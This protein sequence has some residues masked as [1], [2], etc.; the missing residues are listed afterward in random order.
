MHQPRPFGLF[1]VG[2]GSSPYTP[3]DAAAAAGVMRLLTNL[4]SAHGLDSL[5]VVR[6]L[7]GGGVCVTFDMG[8]VVKSLIVRPE[9]EPAA[10]TTMGLAPD[11]IPMLFSGKVDNPAPEAGGGVELLLTTTTRRRLVSY[12]PSVALP[13]RRQALQRFRVAYNDMHSEFARSSGLRFFSQYADLRPTWFSGAMAA[14][15]QV[16]G[17]YGRQDL[18]ALPQIAIERAAMKVP[19]LVAAAIA[20]EQTNTRLPGYIGIPPRSGQIQYDYKFAQTHA[21]AFDRERRP[22][23]LRIDKDGVFA[24]PLPMIPATTTRAFRRFVEDS[25]D[26][27][28]QEV[29]DRFGGMPS[30]ERFPSGEAFEAWRRAGVIIK[31]CGTGQFYDPEHRPYTMACGWSLNDS[32]NEGFNTCWRYLDGG[33]QMGM[34][35]KL[36]LSLAAAEHDG[37]LPAELTVAIGSAAEQDALNEYLSALYSE[38]STDSPRDLAIKY[39]LRR[40]PEKVLERAL[41]SQASPRSD[42]D[43]W[44]NLEL[45]PIAMHTGSVT[46]AHEG[47]LYHPAKFEFQPQIKF[48]DPIWNGCISHDFTPREGGSF[49]VL[50]DTIMFGYYVGDDLKVVKYFYDPRGVEMDVDHNYEDC[51]IVGSWYQDVKIG[52]ATVQGHFYTSDFDERDMA[53]PQEVNTRIVGVDR[54]Y[55]HTPWFS[56]DAPYWRPGT[57]WRNRYYTHETTIVRSDGRTKGT[58]ICIPYHCRCAALHMWAE[59]TTGGRVTESLALGSVRDPNSY[60]FW[61]HDKAFHFVGRVGAGNPYPYDANPVWVDIYRYSPSQC[62]DFADQGDWVGGLPADYTW[63]IHPKSSEYNLSGGGGMPIVKERHVTKNAD[64]TIIRSLDISLLDSPEHVNKTPDVWYGEVSPHPIKGIF[65]R[66]ATRSVCGQSVYGVV[67]EEDPESP[68]RLKHWGHT[69]LVDHKSIPHFIGVI[70]E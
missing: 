52:S 5:K 59:M 62:S 63:L 39:K 32:G 53:A 35:F 25:E 43:F 12:D 55:D 60:E 36:R 30:G 42:V 44:D 40:V 68:G 31:V 50:C 29:L 23:L 10:A 67:T 48:P 7:P 15:V 26:S 46:K 3:A 49:S 33:L 16:V 69:A 28:L 34:A 51:M 8:G 19:P 6:D 38:A 1:S 11:Y 70:N 27:E 20:L 41:A 18:D 64:S 54:G 9:D 45:P 24:M 17:G 13:S 65:Y 21:V 22:W 14:L 58:A 4:K 57:M 47:P 37:K 2:G 66:S 61:T 56:F